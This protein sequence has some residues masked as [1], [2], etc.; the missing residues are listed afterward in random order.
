[1]APVATA[2]AATGTNSL[3]TTVGIMG[4]EA[5][6]TELRVKIP[7]VEVPAIHPAETPQAKVRVAPLVEI[8]QAEV[9]VALPA[10]IPPA[11]VPVA[12]PGQSRSQRQRQR[13][14][15]GIVL[16]TRMV[17]APPMDPVQ[18]HP[19]VR[20]RKPLMKPI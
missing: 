15:A 7:P 9:R 4:A 20:E 1:M 18:E 14:E 12:H 6:T 8:L 13:R 2:M 5:V 17:Q 3:A 16:G 19:M 11:E 10:K